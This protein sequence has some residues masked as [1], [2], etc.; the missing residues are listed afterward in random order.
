MNSDYLINK[1]HTILELYRVWR[2]YHVWL[3]HLKYFPRTSYFYIMYKWIP[4]G[5]I[6][7]ILF[8]V[9]PW[10]SWNIAKVG[11]KHQSI[12]L[13]YKAFN[14]SS[15]HLFNPHSQTLT[16]ENKR[17]SFN[18]K[19]CWCSEFKPLENDIHSFSLIM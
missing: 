11:V 8:G 12:N 10:Y 2:V 1:V 15:L 19:I 18:I 13:W 9:A 5:K 14:F 16:T 4:Y 17:Q 6:C 3:T 7:L